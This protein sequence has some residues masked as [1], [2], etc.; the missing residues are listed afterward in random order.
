M[1]YRFRYFFLCTVSE[2]AIFCFSCFT[3]KLYERLTA[4]ENMYLLFDAELLR[5]T[6]AKSVS[7]YPPEKLLSLGALFAHQC[8]TVWQS[9]K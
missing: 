7:P 8:I 1:D 9:E 4:C 5:R 6:D 2:C 3:R